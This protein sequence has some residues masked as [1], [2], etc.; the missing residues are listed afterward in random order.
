MTNMDKTVRVY[1]L[2]DPQQYEDEKAY[3]RSK[4]PEERLHALGMIRETGF[5][6]MYA[7]KSNKNENQQRLRRVLR[8]VEPS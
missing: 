1:D 6:L 8:V 3:W 7:N 2:N 4:T 5:K